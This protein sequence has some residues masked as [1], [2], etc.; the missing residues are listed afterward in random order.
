MATLDEIVNVQIQ[1]NTTAVGRADFGTLLVIGK[2]DEKNRAGSVIT[3][4]NTAGL[5]SIT[6]ETTKAAVT[7]ALSQ[8]PKPLKV[9]VGFVTNPEA[10]T[11]ADL[12]SVLD[13]DS[14]WYFLGLASNNQH[15][16][17]LAKA[18]EATDKML[19]LTCGDL[20]FA[21][22]CQTA[23]LYR[24]ALVVGGA[25][26]AIALAVRGGSYKSGSET[27]A[28]KQLAGVEPAT[29]SAQQEQEYVNANA[30]VYGKYTDS[31]KLTKGGKVSGGEWID[32][33]R[34]RD[35]LVDTMRSD[36]VFMMINRGKLPYTDA[37][38]EVIA[39]T[40]I[41][42]LEEGV[43]AGGIV[44]W[45][46]NTD[47]ETVRGY[48]VDVPRASD[49]APNVKASRV[50]SVGFTAQLAGAVHAITVSGNFQYDNI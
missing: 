26:V 38:L 3:V 37:G 35:W 1:L 42:S 41:R 20:S 6:D 13:T 9:K 49:I 25:N 14:K 17:V 48:R 24:T 39:N 12:Q 44:D 40:I 32:V 46:E 23:G 11:A 10:V 29:I 4:N 33:I 36:L 30:T 16:L 18:V 15:Q 22:Q 19:F 7:V 5:K 34:F 31:I 47:G 28:L 2:A 50:A 43:S 8:N 21:K 27:F 45:T